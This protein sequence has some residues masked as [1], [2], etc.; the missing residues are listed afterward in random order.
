M[1]A[2]QLA[3]ARLEDPDVSSTRLPRNF[4]DGFRLVSS[5]E[6]RTSK[7]WHTHGGTY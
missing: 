3:A 7:R 4:A 2:E 6:K 5:L 1:R